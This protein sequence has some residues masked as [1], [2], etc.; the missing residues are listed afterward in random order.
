MFGAVYGDII[1]SYYELHCTKDYN[2]EFHKDS[3]FTDDS[4]L[5]A[6]VCRAILNDPKDIS[7]LKINS[8]AY[9][10][11]ALYRQ[12]YSRFPRAGFGGMF[13]DWAESGEMKRQG[14]YGNGGAMRAVPIGWGLRKS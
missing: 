3:A 7:A 5:T 12:F 10:Y 11:A 6:A 9:E 4:V 1:G 14:S 13:I 8:R 2:F